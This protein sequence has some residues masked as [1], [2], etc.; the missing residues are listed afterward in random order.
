MGVSCF[1]LGAI[2]DEGKIT[3]KNNSKAENYYKKACQNGFK[4]ACEKVKN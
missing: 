2:Y 1:K 3:R 4:E